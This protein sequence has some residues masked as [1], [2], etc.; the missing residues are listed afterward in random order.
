MP[1]L[2]LNAKLEDVPTDFACLYLVRAK[3][4]TDGQLRI[5]VGVTNS[6]LGRWTEYLRGGGFKLLATY[7]GRKSE[8]GL[9]H[10][11]QDRFPRVGPKV[12]WFNTTEEAALEAFAEYCKE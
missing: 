8:F 2:T 3:C 12:E 6:A 1:M 4:K 5:K 11:F 9:I 7:T 10:L